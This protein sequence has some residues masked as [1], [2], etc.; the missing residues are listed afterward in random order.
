MLRVAG[1]ARDAAVL[2][3]DEH[4][5]ADAAVAARRTRDGFGETSL[6]LGSHRGGVLDHAKRTKTASPSTFTAKRIVQPSS[7]A[8]ASPVSSAMFQLCSGQV[9]VLPCT[10]P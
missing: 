3:F 7:G 9:T 10:M 8:H 5:A 6:G 2:R 1:N 4:A